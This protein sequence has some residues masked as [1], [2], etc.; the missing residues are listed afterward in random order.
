MTVSLSF[1]TDVGSPVHIHKTYENF[2]VLLSL[3]K[4]L[5]RRKLHKGQAHVMCPSVFKSESRRRRQDV[6]S[7]DLM[8]LDCD[9]GIRPKEFVDLHPRLEMVIINTFS[10]T[11][12]NPRLRA[13]IPFSQPVTADAYHII[14][15]DLAEE[16]RR[17]FPQGKGIDPAKLGP[18]SVFYLPVQAADPRGNVFRHYKGGMR[19]PLDPVA[20]IEGMDFGEEQVEQEGQVW[21]APDHVDQEA[22][23]VAIAKWRAAA[24]GTGNRAFFELGLAL[25]RAG[26]SRSEVETCMSSEVHAARSSS[27]RSKQL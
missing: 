12:N 17:A 1:L 20:Y 19:K 26:M 18:E 21:P 8:I 22:V 5:H 7:A 14:A 3:F 25:K 16:A 24:P 13:I 23:E 9:G 2:D 27:H 10:S 15:H 6:V 11:P 4:D